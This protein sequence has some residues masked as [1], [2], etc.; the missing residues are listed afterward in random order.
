MARLRTRRPTFP[1]ERRSRADKYEHGLGV[2]Q[3]YV[4]AVA[5]Y[6][7]SAAQ[8]VAPAMYSL[9]GM[10]KNG[11]GVAPNDQAAAQWWSKAAACMDH[12]V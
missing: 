5:W 3:D 10:N 11:L 4:Q 2:E 1:G 7:K 12:V 6:L 9:G 8:G